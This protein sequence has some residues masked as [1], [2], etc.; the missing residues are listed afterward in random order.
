VQHRLDP[1][2]LHAAAAAAG[3]ALAEARASWRNTQLACRELAKESTTGVD[4]VGLAIR[5]CW[6]ARDAA[7]DHARQRRLAEDAVRRAVRPLIAARL[8]VAAIEEAAGT[9]GGHVLDWPQIYSILRD[10]VARARG[11]VSRGPR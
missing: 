1:A 2:K 7:L 6:T 10:E 4:E 5:L 11:S 8:S 9:A 3:Q